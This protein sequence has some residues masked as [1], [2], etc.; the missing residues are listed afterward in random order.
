LN[1]NYPNPFNPET[2]IDFQ[3]MDGSFVTV[4]IYNLKGQRIRR[5]INEVKTQGKHSVI[6]NGT[7][8]NGKLVSSGVYL[9]RLQAGDFHTTRKMLMMK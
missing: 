7:D 9:Y 2:K 4:D 3:I 1:Q 6:W 5:L 8:E